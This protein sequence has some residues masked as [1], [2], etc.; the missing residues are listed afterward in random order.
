MKFSGFRK[1]SGKNTFCKDLELHFHVPRL[2]RTAAES[3]FRL[4]REGLLWD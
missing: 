4:L 2:V 3:H 1:N